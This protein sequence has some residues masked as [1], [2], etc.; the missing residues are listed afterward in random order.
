MASNAPKSN[1]PA[2]MILGIISIVLGVVGSI[3]SLV[4]CCGFIV[5]MPVGGFG[6]LLGVIG[7]IVG[8]VSK[9][10]MVLPI[11]GSV[12]SVLSLIIGG[13]W[14]GYLGYTSNRS[15]NQIRAVRDATAPTVVSA[16]E[17]QNQYSDNNV[18]ADTKYK[19][20]VLE[21]SGEVVDRKNSVVFYE[22]RL[23]T[24]AATLPISCQFN[25]EETPQA[26]SLSPG[27]KVTIRGLCE[28]QVVGLTLRHCIVK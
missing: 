27:Q 2:P 23:K 26:Q 19:G 9:Q 8:M 12:F 16:V 21:V 3:I 17:L 6:L 18:A 14:I 25:S 5:G 15:A 11:L 1:N 22:V 7:L 13:L 10:G 20:Q 4:P 28:G 24:G